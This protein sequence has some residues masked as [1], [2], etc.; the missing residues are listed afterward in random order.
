MSKETKHFK[1]DRQYRHN[2]I[3]ENIGEG[4]VVD[5]FEVDNHHP[6]G[7]EIHEVTDTAIIIV[8]N[9]RT[10]KKVTELIASPN[11]IKRYYIKEG[12]QVPKGILAKAIEHTRKCYNM[13]L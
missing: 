1:E 6:N 5:K 10:G 2:F 4:E 13:I 11:Q 8:K 12:K 9:K 3:V 7:V